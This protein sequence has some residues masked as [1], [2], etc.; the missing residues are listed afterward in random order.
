MK[1]RNTLSILAIAVLAVTSCND[2]K[3]PA[4][5]SS[6]T[7]ANLTATPSQGDM[8]KPMWDTAPVPSICPSNFAIVAATSASNQGSSTVKGDVA[9]SPGNIVAGFQAGPTNTYVGSGNISYGSGTVQGT[10][11]VRGSV[12]DNAHSVAVSS[13]N[14]LM[15]YTPEFTY[16][17]TTQGDGLLLAPGTHRFENLEIAEDG[18]LFLDFQGN[19]TAQ[20][21][22]QVTG[23]LVTKAG[24]KAMVVNNNYQNC[25]GST[26]YWAV[27][28][29]S[30]DGI[31]FA[32]SI[33]ANGNIAVAPNV[34]VDGKLW[35][36]T[37]SVS[38]N[39]DNV[40]FCVCQSGGTGTPPPPPPAPCD[41]FITGGGWIK[42]DV[43]TSGKNNDKATFGV[44]G[45][46]KNGGPWGNL[47]YD[48]HA[49]NVKVKSTSVTSYTHIDDVTRKIEGIA[50][51]NGQGSFNYTVIVADNGEPGR[52]DTFSLELSN[53]YKASGKLGG[54]N[55][56]L[57]K[58]CKDKRDKDKDKDK[59]K[60]KNDAEDK[61][62][63]KD[64][65][66][67]SYVKVGKKG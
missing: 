56:Q 21:I 36:L 17:G 5:Q 20:V 54:G 42:R 30:I 25:D 3:E 14:S 43:K 11:Y 61:G 2:P 29:A 66:A 53:G 10:I 64:R 12:A 1:I 22:I 15:A 47:S 24:S 13:Y 9:I 26:V 52:N 6:Q 37:G 18:L 60:A 33:V 31:G 40:S 50:K 57:H 51:V 59:D 16:T 27:G 45:G 7:N 65:P 58:G 62:P 38:L 19:P 46:I 23:S 4:P 41:D 35:S 48:D 8:I 55:I 28:S 32:G 49:N 39:T 44:S 63:H 67:P 34:I